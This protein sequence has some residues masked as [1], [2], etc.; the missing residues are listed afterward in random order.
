M[1]SE[2]RDV[3]RQILATVANAETEWHVGCI[4]GEATWNTYIQL[5]TCRLMVH[6]GGSDYTVVYWANWYHGLDSICK[7]EH[8]AEQMRQGLI[9]A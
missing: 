5:L 8:I 9:H 4:Y 7:L 1:T 3:L 6:E 2:E